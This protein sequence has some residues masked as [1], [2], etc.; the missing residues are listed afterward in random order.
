M[1]LSLIITQ[2]K[3]TTNPRQR[4][5]TETFEYATDRPDAKC[6]VSETGVMFPSLL[7]RISDPLWFNVDKPCDDENEISKLEE[8]QEAWLKAIAEKDKDV[9]PIG[10]NREHIDEEEEDEEDD[11]EDDDESDTTNDDEL[12]TDMIDDRESADDADMD[13]NDSSPTWGL[14]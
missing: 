11:G 7:P 12:D 9:V 14:Q 8:E 10:R 4:L 5:R 6:V 3:K 2:L 13:T 1:L